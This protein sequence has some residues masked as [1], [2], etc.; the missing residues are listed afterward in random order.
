MLADLYQCFPSVKSWF[1]QLDEMFKDAADFIPSE[2]IVC[3]PTSLTSN[4][5][6]RLTR[7]L[8]DFSN[9]AQCGLT[10]SFALFEIL[11]RLK[12]RSDVMVGPVRRKAALVASG[13]LHISIE[14]LMLKLFMSF[15][16]SL[17]NSRPDTDR[18]FSVSVH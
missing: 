4:Q 15:Q 10:A 2:L 13:V 6:E 7:Y 17:K 3:S 5:R 16:S 9:G 11:N 12:I 14:K 18:L 8:T 1:D